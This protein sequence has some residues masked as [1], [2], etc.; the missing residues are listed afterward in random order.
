MRPHFSRST[1]EKVNMQMI[2]GIKPKHHIKVE[3]SDEEIARAGREA[4]KRVCGSEKLSR[5]LDRLWGISE[6]GEDW[7]GYGAAP[8][9]REVIEE[10]RD[11]ILSLEEQPQIFPT[12]DKSI[13]LE[14]ELPDKSYLEIDVYEDK[15]TAMQI[16][17]KDYENAKFWN[18]SYDD[19]DQIQQIVSDF[20]NTK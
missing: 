1:V 11:I 9:P 14:Y 4:F 13:Q 17:Q 2:L 18:L 3:L 19:I 7:N 6:L 5:N 20:I 12:A 8:I 15:I 16:P 10:V